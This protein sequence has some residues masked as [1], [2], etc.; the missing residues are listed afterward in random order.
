M[1]GGKIWD[2]ANGALDTN[3]VNKKYVDEQDNLRLAKT[4]ETL[5]GNYLSMTKR[6]QA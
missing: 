5:L 2:L 1:S 3:A 6:K 4:E